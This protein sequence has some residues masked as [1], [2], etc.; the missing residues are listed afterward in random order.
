MLLLKIG[1][2]P[3]L[4]DLPI[5]LKGQLKGGNFNAILNIPLAG[6]MIVGVKLGNNANRMSQ[7]PN[8][9]L[10]IFQKKAKSLSDGIPSIKVTLQAG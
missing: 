10:K 3:S 9:D 1:W 5:L 2:V 6:G 7:L 8:S 4:G